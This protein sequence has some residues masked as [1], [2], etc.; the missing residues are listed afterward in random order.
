M[1]TSAP[2]MVRQVAV[3]VLKWTSIPN[4]KPGILHLTGHSKQGT[5][6]NGEQPPGGG[7]SERREGGGRAWRKVRKS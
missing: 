7:G 3:N 4:K 6:K 2:S 5:Q 1:L